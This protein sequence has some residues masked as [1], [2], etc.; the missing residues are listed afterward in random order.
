MRLYFIR[1]SIYRYNSAGTL[2]LQLQRRRRRLR[3]EPLLLLL[4]ARFPATV[5]LLLLLL[6][7]TTARIT[8]SVRTLYL[9]LGTACDVLLAAVWYFAH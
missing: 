4:P 8:L 5:L 2:R 9:L 1:Y 3:L 7:T 6:L